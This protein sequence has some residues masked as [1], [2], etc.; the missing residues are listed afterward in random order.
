MSNQN[1][2][3]V[4]TYEMEPELQVAEPSALAAITEGEINVQVATAKRFPRNLD[5]FRK[6]ALSLA[7]NS[8]EI[9]SRCFYKLKRGGKTIEG[10][11][12]RLAEIVIASW[13]NL[14]V[15]ARVMDIGATHIK[16]Q[17]ICMDLENNT[18]ISMEVTRRITNKD[19]VRYNDDMITVTCNAANAIALRNAVFKV[20]PY[21]YVQEIFLQA[22]AAAVGDIKTLVDRRASMLKAFDEKGIHQK[23][24]LAYIGRAHVDEI[25]LQ[26]MEDLIGVYNGIEDGDTTPEEA[27]GAD[28]RGGKPEI[29]EP[30]SKAEAGATGQPEATGTEQTELLGGKDKGKKK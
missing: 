30:K 8:Q 22:K 24:I 18:A 20:V 9:A 29:S 19:G 25:D 17:G 12:V 6:R 1:E 11:S 3:N 4:Q 2:S 13:Q 23:K 14:R 21:A 15:A 16:S 5:R 7:L 27:F 10:P 28:A 26:D